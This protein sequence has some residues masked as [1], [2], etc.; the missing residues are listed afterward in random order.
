[1]K[2][3]VCGSREQYMGPTDSVI[4]VKCVDI[5]KVGGP[6]SVFHVNALLVK[7]KKMRNAKRTIFIRI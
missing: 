2:K 3:D 1:M 4:P 6:V 7:K 5:Q